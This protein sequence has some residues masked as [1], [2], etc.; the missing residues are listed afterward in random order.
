MIHR[1]ALLFLRSYAVTLS[2]WLSGSPVF[3]SIRK[4]ESTKV[5]FVTSILFRVDSPPDI[6]PCGKGRAGISLRYRIGKEVFG[7]T[8]KKLPQPRALTGRAFLFFAY[9][10]RNFR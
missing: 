10:G 1:C 8:A 5:F 6:P 4:H 3:A 2:S 9:P 7:G